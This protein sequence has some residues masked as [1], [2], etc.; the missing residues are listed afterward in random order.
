METKAFEWQGCDG[1]E[2]TWEDCVC[3]LVK[4]NCKPNGKWVLK[5]EYFTA[6]PQTEAELLRRGWHIAY[7]ANKTR[8]AMPD[9]VER[10]A[11]FVQFVSKEFGLEA[12]CSTVGMSCGGLYA[13]MLAAAHPELVDVL[14]IDAPVL[15]LLSCPCGMGVAQSGLYEGFFA[16]T[17]L[18]RSAM[19]SYREH[20][21]DK[22][23]ILLQNDIPIVMVAGGADA[24]VPYIENGAVLEKYYTENGGRLKVWIKPGQDHWPHGLVGR[25]NEVV[26]AIE[27]FA[28]ENAAKRK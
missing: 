27:A 20:P 12:R 13:T 26:D 15:N 16:A 1:I 11:R 28:A 19:L 4:P 10:K 2:F 22:M 24:T 7:Q 6:F 9:D 21:I 5:T 23:H 14:Y 3:K 17:G 25:E 8:W 18:T